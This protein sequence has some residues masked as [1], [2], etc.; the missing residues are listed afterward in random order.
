MKLENEYVR[1]KKHFYVRFEVFT[2]MYMLQPPAHC[3]L[4][5]IHLP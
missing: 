2:A 5:A 1:T 4:A 3:I